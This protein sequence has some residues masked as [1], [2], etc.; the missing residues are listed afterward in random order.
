MLEE[1]SDAAVGALQEFSELL[2]LRSDTEDL[3]MT[4]C[5]HEA[6]FRSLPTSASQGE[7]VS[8]GIEGVVRLRLRVSSNKCVQLGF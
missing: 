6:I 7:S 4:A 5:E 2:E 8:W 1:S 3:A